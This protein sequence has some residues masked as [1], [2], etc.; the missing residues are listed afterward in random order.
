MLAHLLDP[1]GSHAQHALFL[2]NFLDVVQAAAQRQRKTFQLPRPESAQVWR[3]RREVPLP[4]GQADVVLHGP[5]LLLIIENKILAGDQEAQLR[6]YWNFA[7]AEAEAK[8]LLPVII[9]LTPD[10]HPPPAQSVSNSP[11]LAEKLVLLSYHD[12]IHQF[13]LRSV[14][15][16]HAVSV[17]E[18]L[19]QYAALVRNLTN[20]VHG[21]R[22]AESR[23]VRRISTEIR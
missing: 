19:R 23:Y 6:R 7:T 11:G 2:G 5:G 16:L 13:I 1:S 22:P 9:Y 4:E 3:C 18:I 14:E 12:D 15:A 21:I 20:G 10:G 8:R 17:A